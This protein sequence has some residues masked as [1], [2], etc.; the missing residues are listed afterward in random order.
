MTIDKLDDVR[1]TTVI[2]EVVRTTIQGLT[3]NE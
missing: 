2:F 1:S 3:S